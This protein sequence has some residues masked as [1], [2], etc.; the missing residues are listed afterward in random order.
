MTIHITRWGQSGPTVIC[1]HGSAQGSQIGGDIHFATQLALAERGYQ[2]LVP[3]R[4][5]HGRSPA[6][7]QP[8]DAELDGAWVA[9]DL[10]AKLPGGAHLVGHS[11]GAAVALAAAARQPRAVRS[12]TLIEPG[13]QKLASRDPAVRRFGMQ[14]LAI[15]YLSRSAAQRAKRFAAAVG[16]PPEIGGAKSRAELT[17]MGH[18]LARLKVPSAPML[19]RQLADIAK[20]GIPLLVVTG[21][22]HPAF[23]ATGEAVAKLGNG[24]RSVIASPHHFPNQVSDEFNQVLATFMAKVDARRTSAVAF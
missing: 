20:A 18:G 15:K 19:Q 3:D 17:A 6:N 1:I 9:D 14:L 2:L 4:P 22:W 23:E 12:L 10:L 5:G 11:F 13:M 24:T 7:G 8:D 16:I 21:G